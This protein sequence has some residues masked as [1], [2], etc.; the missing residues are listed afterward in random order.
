MQ[1]R[2]SLLHFVFLAVAISALSVLTCGSLR[3]QVDFGSV[4]GTIKDQSGAVIPGAKV[5]LR[6]EDTGLTVTTTTGPDG[7]YIFSPVKIGTYE[8][9]TEAAGFSRAVQSHLTLHI[10]QKLVVDLSLKPGVVTQTVEVTAAPP[11][12]QTQDASV[13]QVVNARSVNDLP[14]NGRNFTFLAQVVAGVNTPQADTRGN[15]ASGAFAAN[16]L[17]PSQNNYLLDGIDN[18]SDNV[19]FLNGTNFVVLP[20]PDALSEFK[21]QTSDFSAQYGRAGGAILNA[22][23]KSGT[24]QIHGNLWEFARNDKLDAADFFE[25]EEGLQKGEFRQNQF[26]FTIGG[27][28]VIPHVF[29][30]RNKLFFFGDAEWL[31]RR[32]GSVFTNSV[33]T[34]LEASSGYTNLADNLLG[35][36]NAS[37]LSSGACTYTDDL[38]RTLPYGIIT[39]PATTRS[40]T[41]GAVD[42]VTGL[43]ATDSGWVED[44]FYTGGAVGNMKNFV[45]LGTLCPT[46]SGC[47]LNQIPANRIDPNALKL[48]GLYPAAT[49]VNS[50]QDVNPRIVNN[51]ASNPVL[52]ENRVAFDTRMDWNKGDKDQIFGT[53]SYVR[54]PQF[55]PAPFKGIADGGAFQQG[56]QD[57]N[58]F[59]S[60]VSYTH[61]FSPTLVNEARLGEDRLVASRY[62]PVATNLTNL[63]GQYGV[64]G[65]AQVSENGGLPAIGVGG[66]NTL[67]SN[68]YLPSDEITQTT[69][70]TENLTKIYG[71]HSF[72]MG[73]EFQH[74]KFSTLQ[75]AWSHGQISFD[76]T[77]SGDGLSQLLLT[78]A[79][80]AVP[81]GIDYV[82]GADSV[83]VSNFSPTDD[84]HNYWAGYFQDDWKVSSKLTVNLGLRWEH[85]GQVVENHGRQANFLPNQVPGGSAQYLEPNNGK[86]QAIDVNP[87]FPA[88]LAKDGI[89]LKYTNLL[90]LATV[91]DTNFGPRLGLAYQITPK[92]VLRTGAGIFYNAFEN[93]GYGPNI[94]ENYPFQYTLSYFNKNAGTPISLKTNSGSTC[95]PAASIE[96]TFSCIPLD[97]SLVDPAGLGL[98]GRQYNYITPY[99]IGWNFTLQYELSPNTALTVAYV[100]NGS[101]HDNALVGA[102]D[103]TIIDLNPV[104]AANSVG[105]TDP[106]PN[107]ANGGSYQESSGT[108]NYAALQTTLERRFSNGLNFLANYTWS[109]CR[110]DASDP[111]N[112]NNNEGWRA[113]W[114]PGLGIQEDYQNCDYN[115]FDVA[116]FSG[117]YVLPFGKG[118]RF[119][120]QASGVLNQ[121]VN[122]W[123]GVWN[124]TLEGGQPYTI[125]CVSGTNN[126]IGCDALINKSVSPYGTG[127]VNQFWNPNY[128]NQPCPAPGFS[129]PSKCVPLSGIPTLTA[130]TSNPSQPLPCTPLSA[131]RG[132][133]GGG[134]AQVNGPGIGRLDFSLFKNFQINERSRLEFRAEFFNITNHPTFNSPGFSGNGVVA[135]S[136][137]TSYTNT[138]FGKIGSTRFPFQD[139]RQIQFALKL[140]F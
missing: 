20:P 131:C 95:T 136:G 53:F 74:I 108:S 139:P 71:K 63:P 24:N 133:L 6:S 93:V 3:A 130:P 135:V 37:C 82:G 120:P 68:A 31:R 5:S 79:T 99:T 115:I 47:M 46:N 111:L 90:P 81:G 114:V 69:Q 11:A 103:P 27:P 119:L 15:A 26:G 107:F 22:S 32:Q 34:P 10:D 112:D 65:I 88:L 14:L 132:L 117:G 18:N 106:F 137:S 4:L 13:G 42:P 83:F 66:L 121:M 125:G 94:G 109:H 30:G 104:S 45:N 33:P 84:G 102:N 64:Q 78:P 39:D 75:P 52:I 50:N 16:G 98:E 128:F 62:G 28:V 70:A 110:E 72:K 21:V 43:T 89:A 92:L 59:L 12:L 48:L 2:S 7:S 77:F 101:R 49:L 8:V 29:D 87:A 19:N 127:G 17:R 80:S 140:Y 122:G 57:A 118:N 67:G 85:F 9:S 97:V 51:Q 61:I 105:S 113:A 116:H 35:S 56:L 76:G 40:V 36:T 54:D 100:G 73:M 134:D 55:I 129:Q 86:N 41:A 44:P 96:A 124:L 123:Q 38:G 126:T 58:S 25:D 60:S 91:P 138:N 1:R 23:I